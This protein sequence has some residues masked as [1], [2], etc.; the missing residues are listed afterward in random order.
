[1]GVVWD[2][3]V[4]CTG[5]INPERKGLPISI[6]PLESAVG[7]GASLGRGGDLVPAKACGRPCL[8]GAPR[9]ESP[10]YNGLAC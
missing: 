1:M 4:T 9:R 10:T 5:S 6:D 8:G 3:Y 2:D 7:S